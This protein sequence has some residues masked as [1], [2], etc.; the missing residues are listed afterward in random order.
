MLFRSRLNSKP[1]PPASRRANQLPVPETFA[2]SQNEQAPEPPT[3]GEAEPV[4]VFSA[5]PNNPIFTLRISGPEDIG[6]AEA[7]TIFKGMALMNSRRGYQDA[8]RGM[9]IGYT[10]SSKGPHRLDSQ[11]KQWVFQEYVLMKKALEKYAAYPEISQRKTPELYERWIQQASVHLTALGSSSQR[12]RLL[13]SL[14]TQE[15]GKVHWRNFKPT[16]GAAVD[17]GFGQFLPATAK[18]VGINPYDPEENIKGIALYLNQ[19]IR[20][21]GMRNGLASYNGGNNPPPVSYRYAD[22]IMGR[23]G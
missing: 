6:R 19:L 23:M 10:Y 20:R 21:K 14:M 4:E 1:S 5:K 2:A 3:S 9:K 7:E 15:S 8:L 17:I 16:M 22:S 13:K 11:M 18:S 12:Y